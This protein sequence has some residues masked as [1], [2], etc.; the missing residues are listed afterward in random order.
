MRIPY[1]FAV[2]G[3]LVAGAGSAS[4]QQNLTLEFK[5]GLVSLSAQNVA[6]SQ[7]LAEWA[8]RG[9][10][11]IVN[12]ERVPGPAVTL[13][14]QDVTEQ[15]ALEVLLRG[16]SGYLVAARDSALSGAS[17]YDRIYILPTSSRPSSAAQVT[18]QPQQS[19]QAIQEDDDDIPVA[20]GT[21]GL[22]PPG[23]RRLPANAGQPGNQPG[24]AARPPV[25]IDPNDEPEELE[26][27]PPTTPS[28]N[29]PFMGTIPG[30]SRPGV[31]TPG[32][33]AGNRQQQQ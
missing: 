22:N 11:T 7:I 32:P 28:T 19:F 8:R 20:P 16:V 15:Q 10:T 3:L 27:R 25:P 33:P 13:E 24:V 5:N 30:S 2:V 23:A 9:R 1:V 21:R 17:T 31:V 4:A 6:I 26:T 14:L 12:G 29:N 18:P